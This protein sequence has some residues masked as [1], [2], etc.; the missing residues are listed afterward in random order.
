MTPPV[1]SPG[2]VHGRPAGPASR[3]SPKPGLVAA[4]VD[5]ETVVYDPEADLL[6]HLETSAS[7][8]WARLDGTVSIDDLTARI[9]A[10]YTAPPETIRD[11]VLDLAG[12]LWDLGLLDGSSAPPHTTR[13][14]VGLAVGPVPGGELDLVDRPLPEAPYRT[15]RRRALEH[16]FEV[17][18][19]DVT[20]RDY[21]DEVLIGFAQAAAG[22]AAVHELLDLV[23]TAPASTAATP[24]DHERNDQPEWRYVV[25]YDGETVVA[26]GVLD[27]A[28][29]VLLWHVNAEVIR[30]STECYPLVHAGGVVSD[31]LAV[32]LPAPP[33]S[34]K[35]TTV[36]GLLRAG[37][38][39][40]TDEA[41][42]IDP[43]DLLAQ[44]Y[45]KALSVDAGSW[46]VLAD[47][48]PPHAD[49]ISGQWHVPPT[50]VRPDAVAGSAPVRF[51]VTPSY[52]AG[53]TTRLEPISRAASLMV[54]ADSTFNFQ[55]DPRRNLGILR[56]LVHGADCFRLTIGDLDAAVR[57]VTELVESEQ[58]D[59]AE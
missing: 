19:N 58:L 2:A 54:L 21:L 12:V 25:R 45:P 11:D 15:R 56:R 22:E 7:A 4:E 46:E 53:A 27:I 44:P 30:R 47:L 40:L 5:G 24:A 35:T 52:Q 9:A 50:M 1:G 14:P 39:Y 26:T 23:P 18:T 20:V 13:P 31:G 51:V 8:V 41:V 29:T 6:H 43:V 48:R 59:V 42:A 57:L 34:G 49:Q 3:P 37:F 36:A 16:V 33:E 17:V 38:D 32:M 10:A 55:H 28:I